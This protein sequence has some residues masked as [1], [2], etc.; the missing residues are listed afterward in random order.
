MRTREEK[1]VYFEDKKP[2]KQY[3]YFKRMFEFVGLETSDKTIAYLY[4][5]SRLV[6]R[7]RGSTNLSDMVRLKSQIEDRFPDE[8]MQWSNGSHQANHQI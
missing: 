2:E 3:D 4:E 5:A 6:A 8:P 7:K 1:P